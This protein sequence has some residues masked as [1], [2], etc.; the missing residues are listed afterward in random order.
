MFKA[1]RL[2]YHST[3]GSRVTKKKKKTVFICKK[4]AE[5][6]SVAGSVLEILVSDSECQDQTESDETRAV[7]FSIKTNSLAEMWSGS[8][9]GSFKA[10]R[11]SCHS[12]LGSIV[13]KKK[14]KTVFICKKS[15]E[16][17]YVSYWRSWCIAQNAKIR[18]HRTKLDL[19]HLQEQ[20]VEGYFTHE[21]CPP[22]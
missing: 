15:V 14:R 3:L 16:A 10:Y 9:E 6:R 21:K 4:S 2:V 13:V 17:R 18:L 12:I 8:E 1:H 5:A 19:V 20:A 22:P 7:Q 11:L